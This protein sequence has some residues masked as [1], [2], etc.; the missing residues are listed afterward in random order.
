MP[1]VQG[2][3]F[4]KSFITPAPPYYAQPETLRPDLMSLPAMKSLTPL[5]GHVSAIHASLFFHLFQRDD[6]VYAARAL[7]SLLS[8][9]PGSIIFGR[10]VSTDDGTSKDLPFNY[11]GTQFFYGFNVEDWKRLW[12]GEVFK[13]GNVHVEAELHPVVRSRLDADTLSRDSANGPRKA[14]VWCVTRL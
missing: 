6:Q 4:D 12:N 5:Q 3:I 2:D 13:E 11:D 10:H 9:I 8:P 1:F 14:L 7:A